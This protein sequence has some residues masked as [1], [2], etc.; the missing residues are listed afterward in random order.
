MKHI[1][2]YEKTWN[3]T[4]LKRFIKEKEGIYNL[5]KKFLI[6]EGYTVNMGVIKNG[7]AIID[8]YFAN[9]DGRDFLVVKIEDIN[10]QDEDSVLIDGLDLENLYKFIDNPE[11]YKNT[12]K[13]NL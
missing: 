10:G 12:K 11:L 3:E 1:G 13:Y 7:D 5:I 8:V 2:L 6:E 9:N 4:I